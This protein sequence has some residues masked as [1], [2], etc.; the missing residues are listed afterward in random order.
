M[1]STPTNFDSR[2]IGSTEVSTYM[3][4][5]EGA[6]LP[7]MSSCTSIQGLQGPFSPAT[8]QGRHTTCLVCGWLRSPS[9][10][11]VPPDLDPGLNNPEFVYG[12]SSFTTESICWTHIYLINWQFCS[13]HRDG[14]SSLYTQDTNWHIPAEAS[15]SHGQ[16]NC[17]LQ[18]SAYAHCTRAYLTRTV[19]A[20]LASLVFLNARRH[21]QAA[22]TSSQ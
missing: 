12:V 1:T 8:S 18:G 2:E 13:T 11:A 14:N 17:E 15:Q 3:Y 22:N 19:S 20:T 21:Q 10:H 5:L 9:V 6:G 7:H 4:Y 16:Y